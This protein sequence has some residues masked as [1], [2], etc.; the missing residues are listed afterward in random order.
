MVCRETAPA[1]QPAP[2]AALYPNPADGE[3]LLTPNFDKAAAV[4]TSFQTTVYDGQGHLVIEPTAAQPTLRLRTATWQPGL[5]QVVI[6]Q[7]QRVSRQQ[8]SIQH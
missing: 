8:L 1:P 5:Y 2:I 7:G 6:R 3:V 4:S